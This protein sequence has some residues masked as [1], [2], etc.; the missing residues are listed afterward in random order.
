[1][2]FLVSY[3]AQTCY[4]WELHVETAVC[5]LPTLMGRLHCFYPVIPASSHLKSR[6]SNQ[7][8]D[9]VR[10]LSLQAKRGLAI[11]FF[12][13][14]RMQLVNAQGLWQETFGIPWPTFT[15]QEFWRL[16]IGEVREVEARARFNLERG[17]FR[18]ACVDMLE[19]QGL[20]NG[21]IGIP[22]PHFTEEELRKLHIGEVQTLESQARCY[23]CAENFRYARKDMATARRL[24]NPILGIPRPGFCREELQWLVAKETQTLEDQAIRCS[25]RSLARRCIYRSAWGSNSPSELDGATGWKQVLIES[26]QALESQARS[27]FRGRIFTI[28]RVR[29]AQADGIWDPALGIPRPC[30]TPQETSKLDILRVQALQGRAN[31]A[32]RRQEFRRARLHMEEAQAYWTEELRIPWPGFTPNELLNVYVGEIQEFE[33]RARSDK[34]NNAFHSARMNMVEAQ[35]L[36]TEGTCTP[37]PEFTLLELQEMAFSE[38]EGIEAQIRA[39]A[40][41]LLFE[42]DDSDVATNEELQIAKSSTQPTYNNYA[43]YPELYPEGV[44]AEGNCPICLDIISIGQ[45]EL[46]GRCEHRYHN[47]C[48]REWLV[49]HNSCPMCRRKWTTAF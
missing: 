41:S 38:L 3:L 18:M 39:D 37:R 14:S 26:V 22:Y 44:S 46:K 40:R 47:T 16:T 2:D 17:K 7:I 33:N 24:W 19:A 49:R 9:L 29:M 11:G 20:W 6:I 1:M 35:L 4:S 12:R 15:H 8:M 13:N 48:I 43:L 25:R 5:S 30:F 45:L 28:A 21:N 31:V 42:V 23:F 10:E 34:R 27:S 36:W 32:F